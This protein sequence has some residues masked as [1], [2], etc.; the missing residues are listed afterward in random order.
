MN[1]Y[2]NIIMKLR[3]E[4][5]ISRLELARLIKKSEISVHRIENGSD[6]RLS[7]AIKISKFFNLPID[8]IWIEK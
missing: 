3:K 1:K 7:E 8:K 5:K 6:L 4:K 2:R